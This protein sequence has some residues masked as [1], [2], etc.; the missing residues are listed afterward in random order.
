MAKIEEKA[1]TV[2]K[3]LLKKV[4]IFLLPIIL[5]IVLLSAA[6]YF[7]TIDDGTYKEDDWGNTNYGASQYINSV[8]ADSDGNLK[9]GIDAQEL[10]DKMIDNGCRVD[11]YLSSPE[12]LAIL[13]KAEIVTKYLDTNPD[14]EIDWDE[15]LK[16]ADELRGIIK[17]KRA[18]DGQDSS[19]ATSMSYVDQATFQSYIDDYNETGSATA[20]NNALTH[21]TLK[22]VSTSS[23]TVSKGI[24]S[25]EKYLDLTEDE[26]KAIATV[27]IAEQG[28]GNL[29][30]NAAEISLM[31]NL[32]ERDKDKGY[33]SVYDYV[34]R[35]G[36]F[37]NAA[38]Y[39]DT[40]ATNNG[41]GSVVDYPEV[42]ELAKIILVQGKR[43]LP[44]YIDEH[45]YV[46]DIAYAT[47][48]GSSIDKG[49]IGQYVQFK[50][51]I[52]QEA[53]VGSRNV[54]LLLSSDTK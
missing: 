14:E 8:T 45:D 51:I 18:S 23:S 32:Y 39:M 20:K 48:D 27:S 22:K 37:A 54:D 17:L 28:A 4:I 1:K 36:W 52:H 35:S 13:M 12:E 7:I 50:T 26:L 53:S 15:F 47:N 5:I 29:E 11:K 31:A 6:V 34:K 42:L 46:G 43:T 9:Q 30:G 44:G 2:I 40:F 33:S 24:G 10:W 41:N 3:K 21:Y 19:N 38:S 25:F 16:N 49:D